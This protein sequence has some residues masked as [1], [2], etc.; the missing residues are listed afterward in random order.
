MLSVLLIL[1]ASAE[2]PVAVSSA[3]VQIGEPVVCTVDLGAIEGSRPALS[4][5]AMGPGR[6]WIILEPPTIRR[7]QGGGQ[8]LSW[9]LFALEPDPGVLP[10]PALLHEGAQLALVAPTITIAAALAEG[11]D[12]PRSARGFHVP[13]AMADLSSSK[14]RLL[15][16]LVVAGLG[17]SAWVVMRRRR[18]QPVAEPSLSE[19]LASLGEGVE[20]DGPL[21][22]AWHGELTRILRA[23]YS[24]DHAG[25]SDEEWVE[26]AA[27]T[28]AQRV[29]LRGILASCAAVKYGGARPTRF[30]VE[31]TL[32]RA[33]VLISR[34]EEVAA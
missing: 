6:G 10:T 14:M 19:R 30:A 12:A 27:L 17:L 21:V 26:R 18:S 25:W 13:P 34:S 3:E 22:V 16:L 5:E 15:A 7:A 2:L 4:E 31:E 11:E 32:E 29:E 28:E 33:R 23:A 20:G 8:T 24:D 1:A 9:T